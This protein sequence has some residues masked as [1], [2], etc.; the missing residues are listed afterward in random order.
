MMCGDCIYV[1]NVL[2]ACVRVCVRYWLVRLRAY[3]DDTPTA[4]TI[5]IHVF[6][7]YGIRDLMLLRADRKT[8]ARRIHI[9]ASCVRA[10]GRA[11]ANACGVRVHYYL[12]GDGF[13]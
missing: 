4:C 11:W 3:D 10:T 2:L 7:V 6:C 5:N 13:E 1:L 9:T 12:N 8:C